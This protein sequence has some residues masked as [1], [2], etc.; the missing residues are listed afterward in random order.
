[1]KLARLLA[2]GAGALVLA[3]VFMAYLRPDFLLDLGN[4]IAM[5]F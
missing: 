5:C 3:L 1:M 4:R 2:W